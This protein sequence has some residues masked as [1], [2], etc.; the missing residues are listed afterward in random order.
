MSRGVLFT[1]P[2]PI[3]LQAFT[4]HGASSK[5]KDNPIGKFGTGLK[6]AI[7]VLCR[8][9]L[10]VTMFRDGVVYRFYTKETEMRVSRF[11]QVHMRRETW[12]D[13]ILK[14]GYIKLPFTTNFG[15]NWK[16][17]QVFRELQS[18]T[19]DE[20]GTTQI[21]TGFGVVE[22]LRHESIGKTLFLV[23][24]ERFVQEYLDRER[25]F[26]P[27]GLTQREGT[28]RIQILDRPSAH[29]Y[30]RGM[31]VHDLETPSA[32]TYNF[33]GDIELTEDRTAANYY[34]LTREIQQ[35]LLGSQDEAIIGKALV[36]A[37]DPAKR[38]L[39]SSFGYDYFAP[40]SEAFKSAVRAAPSAPA[41]A[42]NAVR[43]SEPRAAIQ[44]PL[45]AHPRPW[46]LAP[47]H[48]DDFDDFVVL[49]SDED[50]VMAIN[51]KGL[52]PEQLR[53]IMA[54]LNRDLDESELDEWL[55]AK[56]GEE[57]SHEPAP[58]IFRDKDGDDVP[59]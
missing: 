45:A 32:L 52:N 30:Y 2:E 50:Q 14:R 42:L 40:P 55:A 3:D 33:L 57:L 36:R 41:G 5:V 27:G 29:L 24:G 39:E 35:T 10:L 51:S 9:G 47:L 21:W 49:D 7:A 31:R 1:T 34:S 48:P 56:P 22:G 59:F 54:L 46:R 44:N 58:V 13:G 4:L 53:Y 25:T 43:S 16:L 18:N 8:E 17:W 38:T 19:M 11:W 26:L 37:N 28:D 23:E 12:L 15:I 6:Y 20:G